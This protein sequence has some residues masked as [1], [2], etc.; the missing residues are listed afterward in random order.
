MMA[1][2]PIVY[3]L[4]GTV[5]GFVLG[6]MV[7]NAGDAIQVEAGAAAPAAAAKPALDANELRA[8]ES[9]ARRAPGSAQARIALG[10]LL[11]DHERYEEAARWYREAVA[12][13]PQNADA[14]V[15]LGAC[16]V[17]LGRPA[18]AIAELDAALGAVPGHKQATF[19]KGIALVQAG[20][21]PEAIALWEDLL[22][23]HP[24]DPQ[25]AGLRRQI[26]ELKARG[27]AS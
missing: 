1:R 18:E 6:Y 24:E 25:L 15:D 4:A 26:D 13:Q 20:R 21:A 8:L 22:K 10:N 5:F 3:A 19:N 9:L 7:A 27:G 17:N 14:R 16:L 11:M 23:R 12:L 2:E